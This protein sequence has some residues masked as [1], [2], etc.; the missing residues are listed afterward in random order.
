M[1]ITRGRWRWGPAST[2]SAIG[3]QESVAEG[4]PL[5]LLGDQVAQPEF[6]IDLFQPKADGIIIELSLR[7]TV[8][9]DRSG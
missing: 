1:I 8:G 5:T 7:H 3:Q 4:S 9:R 6:V 2:Q